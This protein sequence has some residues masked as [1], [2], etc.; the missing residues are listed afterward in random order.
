MGGKNVS[1]KYIPKIGG[2]KVCKTEKKVI[3]GFELSDDNISFYSETFPNGKRKPLGF[4]IDIYDRSGVF[5]RDN[6]VRISST[7]S[8]SEMYEDNYMLDN[9]D[10][11]YTLGINNPARLGVGWHYV[12]FQFSKCSDVPLAT[13]EVV[14][15]LVGNVRAI[16]KESPD[17]Y[18]KY[19]ARVKAQ[20]AGWFATGGAC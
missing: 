20:F 18:N 13:F 12:T 4:E 3:V 5:H 15:Q 10:K 1:L 17:I 6:I 19:T 11:L 9:D 2:I 14:V 16:M 7:F 8:K